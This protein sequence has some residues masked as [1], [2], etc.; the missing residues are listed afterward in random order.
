[1]HAGH[2]HVM[3]PA[4]TYTHIQY[5]RNSSIKPLL[6]THVGCSGRPPPYNGTLMHD[7]AQT[8]T[9]THTT[10]QSVKHVVLQTAPATWDRA[11]LCSLY[12]KHGSKRV[13]TIVCCTSLF[14]CKLR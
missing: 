4:H 10:H 7:S 11:A 5:I 12:K 1:M 2:H 3:M 14:L 9:H 8:H 6:G 13:C